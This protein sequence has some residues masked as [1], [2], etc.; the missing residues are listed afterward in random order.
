MRTDAGSMLLLRN[1][2]PARQ[3]V[4]PHSPKIEGKGIDVDL[5]TLFF[6]ISPIMYGFRSCVMDF[7][8]DTFTG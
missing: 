2:D 3:S 5:P 1:K 4:Q 6:M 8:T 7:N